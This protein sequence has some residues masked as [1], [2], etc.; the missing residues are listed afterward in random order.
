VQRITEAH[1]ILGATGAVGGWAAA[2]WHGA[3]FFDGVDGDGA[4]SPILLCVGPDKK[5]QRRPGIVLLRN[6]LPTSD[7]AV[8]RELRCTTPLRT[9]FDLARLSRGLFESVA[10]IDTLLECGLIDLDEFA[11]YTKRHPGWRGIG[12]ARNAASLALE[13]VRSPPE[14]WLRLT[15]EWDAGLPGLLV[16]RPI[17]DLSG[18]LLGIPDCLEISSA[19]ALE[20]DGEGHDEVAQSAADRERDRRFRDHGLTVVRMTK[21]DMRAESRASV[22]EHLRTAYR[23]GLSRNAEDDRWTL[24]EPPGW[25]YPV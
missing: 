12:L 4:P 7:V 8:V 13:G 18:R 2:H 23:V 10:A 19:T 22:I 17:F 25:T 20:Y 6:A 15:W 16:N 14:T 24:N 1:A 11:A 9:A 3:P 5:P 21:N